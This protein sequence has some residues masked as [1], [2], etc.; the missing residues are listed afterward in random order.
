MTE[1]PKNPSSIV[2]EGS[3]PDLERPGFTALQSH[4]VR[5]ELR[6]RTR[7]IIPP[8]ALN[9]TGMYLY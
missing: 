1:A 4:P 9:S 7:M 8:A 3:F 6:K 5:P 2:A